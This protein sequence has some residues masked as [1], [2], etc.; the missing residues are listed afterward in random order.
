[1][2]YCEVMLR[3]IIQAPEIL[4]RIFITLIATFLCTGAIA[5]TSDIDISSLPQAV[6]TEKYSWVDRWGSMMG[7]IIYVDFR[8]DEEEKVT[9]ST[10]LIETTL[11]KDRATYILFPVGGSETDILI[12]RLNKYG[13]GDFDIGDTALKKKIF[14]IRRL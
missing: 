12:Y 4:K 3:F 7:N 1:M 5:Q 13:P 8:L 14:I 9:F 6:Y 11:Q 10:S 2:Q